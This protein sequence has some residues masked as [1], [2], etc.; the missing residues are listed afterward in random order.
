LLLRE[1]EILTG[2]SVSRDIPR[3]KNTGGFSEL[4]DFGDG[5]YDRHYSILHN[6]GEYAQVPTTMEG[7]CSQ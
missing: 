6:V 5:S 2:D 3:T 7:L 4:R 1:T